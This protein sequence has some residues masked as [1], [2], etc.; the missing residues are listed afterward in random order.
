MKKRKIVNL[1]KKAISSAL[2]TTILLCSITASELYYNFSSEKVN[3]ATISLP[4]GAAGSNS[5]AP[6]IDSVV[7]NDASTGAVKYYFNGQSYPFWQ[8]NA[9][10]ASNATSG[11]A[12]QNSSSFTREMVAAYK[13]PEATWSSNGQYDAA[14]SNSPKYALDATGIWNGAGDLLKTANISTGGQSDNNNLTGT[15]KTNAT[16]FFPSKAEYAANPTVAGKVYT[17]NSKYV[18]S[19]SLWGVNDSGYDAWGVYNASGSLDGYYLYFSSASAPAFNLDLE[20]VLIARSAS[21]GAEAASSTMSAYSVGTDVK[22]VTKTNNTNVNISS[23]SGSPISAGSDLGEL[24]VGQTYKFMY[25]MTDAKALTAI[26]MDSNRNIK[27]IGTLANGKQSGEATLTIPELDAGNYYLGFFDETQ[28]AAYTT[29]TAGNVTTFKFTAAKNTS[30]TFTDNNPDNSTPGNKINASNISARFASGITVNSEAIRIV[31]ASAW[32]SNKSADNSSLT[33]ELTIPESNTGEF[34]YYIV[35]LDSGTYIA[36]EKQTVVSDRHKTFTYTNDN[37]RHLVAGDTIYAD[38]IVGATFISDNGTGPLNCAVDTSIY[39]IKLVEATAWEADPSNS[40][41]GLSD[42]LTIPLDAEATYSYYIVVQNTISANGYLASDKIVVQLAENSTGFDDTMWY[43]FED[44]GVKWMYKLNGVGEIIGLYID[45][46][47]TNISSIMTSSGALVVPD[48]INDRTVTKIG[49]GSEDKPFIPASKA[50][51]TSLS[52][53][54]SVTTIN[55]YAFYQSQ[56]EADIVIPNTVTAIGTKAFFGAKIRSVLLS[57]MQGSIGSYAFSSCDNLASVT[58]KATSDSGRRLDIASGVFSEA[59]KLSTVTISGNV[60]LGDASFRGVTNLATLNL[61]TGSNIN[62]GSHAFSDSNKLTKLYVPQKVVL[63]EYSF[64]NMSALAELE[65]DVDLPAHSFNNCP[66]V[67]KLILDEGV[68]RISYD[69]ESHNSTVLSRNVY[70]KN[71]E[72]VIEYYGKDST[73]YSALGSSGDVEVYYAN[74]GN[75]AGSAVTPNGNVL[76][77]NAITSALNTEYRTYFTGTASTVHF[78]TSSDNFSD[79]DNVKDN[80][81][82]STQTGISAFYN[83]VVLTSKQLDMSKMAVKQMYNSDERDAYDSSQFHVIRTSDFRELNTNSNVTLESI[84]EFENLTA[85]ETDLSST[86]TTSGVMDVTV[87]VF[88]DVDGNVVNEGDAAG[89]FNTAVS[90]RVEKYAAKTYIE[91]QYG[92]YE[93]IANKLVE[94][95]NQINNLKAELA[96]ADVDSIDKL[97]TEL[98]QCKLAYAELVKELEKYVSNNTTDNSGYFGK[99]DDGNG[100][101]VDVIYINGTPLQYEDTGN[102]DSNGNKIYKTTYDADG[103]GTPEEIYVVVKDD[104][105]HLVD[106]DGNPKTNSDGEDIVYK[107]TLGA[108][109]RRLTAQIAAIEVELKKCD[110]GFNA[111]KDALSDAGITID[112]DGDVD[113]YTQIVNAVKNLASKVNDLTTD[114]DNANEQIKGYSGSLD[115]IYGKLTGSTLDKDG[116]EGLTNV[117]NAIIVKIQTLQNDLTVANATV[118]DLQAQVNSADTKISQLQ[119]ELDTTK[120]DLETAE[121]NISKANAEKAALTTQYEAAIAAGDA[122]AAKKLQ[123]QINEKNAYIA[124]LETTKTTLAQKEQDLK[125][126]QDTVK[127]L[128]KQIEAKNAEIAQLKAELDAINSTADSYKVTA[129][130]ANK[131]F[132]LTL[133]DGASADEVKTAI[134][135]YVATMTAYKDTIG[136]IQTAVNSSNN[137]DALVADVKKAVADGNGSTGTDDTVVNK[138]SASYKQGV[139]DGVASVDV[140]EASIPYKNGY[141]NGYNTGYSAGIAANA[142]NSN[143]ISS[144][145]DA[146]ISQLTNLSSEIGTLTSKN[147]SLNNKVSS[148]EEENS[149]LNEQV[150]SLQDENASLQS[151]VSSLEDDVNYL[152]TNKDKLV[153]FDELMSVDFKPSATQLETIKAGDGARLTVSSDK[154]EDGSTY[155]IVH[156]SE[157]RTGIFDILLTRANG[158]TIDITVPDLSPVT[159]VKVSISDNNVS[160]QDTTTAAP[161]ELEVKK[162]NSGKVVVMYVLI[163][164]AIIALGALFILAKKRNNGTNPFKRR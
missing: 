106:A 84:K 61:Q 19:R 72:T 101:E 126:A 64:E 145:N 121:E 122:E 158:N 37:D 163:V 153:S 67:S 6:L 41:S 36:S 24:S 125:D 99:T 164:V 55:D 65:T 107:D 47:T 103:D 120:A 92:S 115:T 118:A 128:Q 100:N 44:N 34:Y 63:N 28:N 45:P 89:F 58:I 75:N 22:F 56:T 42:T 130:V 8:L 11:F 79:L 40:N 51:W 76:S 156:E 113:E 108:L 139:E 133:K 59:S 32:E 78:N 4:S 35:I 33:D 142:N 109:Q 140:S 27:Y 117:L 49:G 98:A 154:F 82:N 68:N 102:T 38:K 160:D 116:I 31:E 16:V 85:A 52:L 17:A 73:Y 104:G 1:C 124:E 162:D 132:G 3:A 7:L 30:A 12:L 87:L 70:I 29:N 148:L 123:A 46:S 97:T 149:S 54:S 50:G 5:V 71:A 147:T 14:A 129:D 94:Y 66:S 114:L 112:P 111:I 110:D 161:V 21:S 9:T 69:W 93:N 81:A 23:A 141:S 150:S 60:N 119:N 95:E 80:N 86:S 77:I 135:E 43:S 143:G 20:K 83:G 62:I 10:G 25:E 90:V 48:K 127:Q 155:F 91:Q 151:Q 134:Q 105:V 15:S 13:T 131:M 26:I 53:P 96:K 137:G 152:S 144:N 159:I 39:P 57:E 2:L 157:T 138:N 88:Y 146:L 18:W 74:G 136:K